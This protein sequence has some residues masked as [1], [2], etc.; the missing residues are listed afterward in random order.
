MEFR[1]ATLEAHFGGANTAL[2]PILTSINGDN[3]WLI[4]FPRPSTDR[5]ASGK[6]FFHIASDAWLAGPSVLLSEWLVSLSLSAPPAFVDGDGVEAL[7][8]EIEG[9]VIAAGIVPDTTTACSSSPS[10]DAIFV[11]F[12]Y[13]DHMDERTLRTFH[14]TT[15]VFAAAE[16][17][18]A[19]RGWQHFDT[20]TA[21]QDLDA[22][23]PA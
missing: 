19:I 2:R 17:A 7:V 1:R 15:A 9:A 20:V 23:D 12:H 16:A 14:A 22:A 13:G 10:V 11:N 18:P 4:S 6:A 3:S 8:C 21:T 5:Q